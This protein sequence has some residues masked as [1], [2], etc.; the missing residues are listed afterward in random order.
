MQGLTS[1][2]GA[3]GVPGALAACQW[4]AVPM[5]YLALGFC[6]SP[7]GSLGAPNL[8]S[9]QPG[10]GTTGQAGV[11]RQLAVGPGAHHALQGPF[12]AARQHLEPLAS[13]CAWTTVL[14]ELLPKI[15][16]DS[17]FVTPQESWGDTL[18]PLSPVGTVPL[19]GVEVLQSEVLP[20][21]GNPL[22]RG[23]GGVT[24]VQSGSIAT[25]REPSDS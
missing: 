14:K 22:L 16:S 25:R 10:W 3:E 12:L 21:K 11:E 23:D 1:L 13:L 24:S 15:C 2:P 20:Y 17:A 9:Q 7:P 4:M 6:A 5:G 18:L 19:G 8:P